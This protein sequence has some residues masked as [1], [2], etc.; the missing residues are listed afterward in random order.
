MASDLGWDPRARKFRILE[1]GNLGN[2]PSFR[3]LFAGVE[4]SALSRAIHAAQPKT[5]DGHRGE[6]ACAHHALSHICGH[7]YR[8]QVDLERPRLVPAAANRTTWKAVRISEIPIN[9]CCQ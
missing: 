2:S 7:S 1:L 4:W 5:S 9:V 8:D 3:Q 6:R